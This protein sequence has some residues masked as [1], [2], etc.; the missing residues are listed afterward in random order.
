MTKKTMLYFFPWNKNGKEDH[1]LFLSMEKEGMLFLSM[2]QE[3]A[4]K[5]TLFI[6]MG[7]E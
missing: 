4:K 1:T 6:S 3:Y 7:L 2:G 5:T